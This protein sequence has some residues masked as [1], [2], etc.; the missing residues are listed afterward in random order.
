[1]LSNVVTVRSWITFIRYFNPIFFSKFYRIRNPNFVYNLRKV[2]EKCIF[3]QKIISEI[4]YNY[5]A[6]YNVFFKLFK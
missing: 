2:Q 1:M 6:G 5:G 3:A 4:A